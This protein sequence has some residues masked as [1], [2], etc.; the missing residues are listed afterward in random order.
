MLSLPDRLDLP[1]LRWPDRLKA[2][3]VETPHSLFIDR[4]NIVQG[5]QGFMDGRHRIASIFFAHSLFTS[6]KSPLFNRTASCVSVNARTSFAASLNCSR[7]SLLMFA[8]WLLA[9]PY[10]KN[11]LAA[12][13]KRMMV[14]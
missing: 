9:N 4:P 12:R 11:A 10:T 1:G 2:G 8:C 14:R 3:I 6:T 13:R 7:S 5:L